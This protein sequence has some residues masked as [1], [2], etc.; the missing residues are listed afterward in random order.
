M[1]KA[2]YALSAMPVLKQPIPHFD[3]RR[4][5]FA[6]L[7]L[8]VVLVGGTLSARTPEAPRRIPLE[9]LGFQQLSLQFLL[10]G[11]SM[12]TLHYVDDTHLLITF[13]VRRLMRRLPDDPVDDQDRNVDALL[14]ELPSG[15]V[16]ARTSWRLHDH[17]QYL[18]S[19]GHGRFLLRVRDTI[20]IFAPLANLAGGEPFRERPF[21][22]TNNRRI[23]EIMVS[24]DDSLLTVETVKRTPP[25]PRPKDPLFGPVPPA[26]PPPITS[27]QINFYRLPPES[28]DTAENLRPQYA[29]VMHA[30]TAGTIPALGGGYIAV[31]D[32]GSPHWAFD[33]DAYSGKKMEL[34]P[35][36]SVCRPVPFFVS[37]SEFIAFGCRTGNSRQLLGAFNMRGEQTWQQN[38]FGDY[39]TPSLDYADARGRFVLSRVLVHEAVNG[40][41]PLVVPEQIGAQTVVVYQTSSGRQLLRAECTPVEPAGQNF[42]LSPDGLSLAL[43]HDNAIE[44]YGLPELTT[45]ESADLK[46]AEAAAPTEDTSLPVHFSVEEKA[47]AASEAESDSHPDTVESSSAVDSLSQAAVAPSGTAP[48]SV[49]S[50]SNAPDASSEGD[51]APN[52]ARPR[53]TL[54]TLPSDPPRNPRADQPQ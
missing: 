24:P 46:L 1:L 15:H 13:N 53:P 18:W 16:L 10:A 50:A 7:G 25:V 44:I 29:G 34:A 20:T 33:F 39:I 12:L 2:L 40:D 48:A 14:L 4:L 21:L 9:P 32:Q 19:I 5:R 3:S 23:A 27:V 51:P 38:L 47:A 37:R 41:Q 22:N 35:F 42:A 11:S 36:D 49:A 43:V 31:I 30:N 54:Y 6:T 52:Q 28:G 17:A 45:K 26:A 8:L